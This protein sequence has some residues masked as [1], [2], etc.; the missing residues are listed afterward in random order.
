MTPTRLLVV[1]LGIS[2]AVAGGSIAAQQQRGAPAPPAAADRVLAQTVAAA[3]AFL[4]QLSP[5]QRAKAAYPFD[6]PQRKNWSN[7]P[8]GIFQRNSLRMGDMTGPQRDTA[9]ALM[10]TV[11]SRDGY[12]KITDIMNGDEV[13][14]NQ[15][16]GRT[17]GRPGAP[18]RGGQPGGGGRGGGVVF[19]KDEYYVAI[20][21][22]PSTST[23]W[24]IQFGGHHLGINL[25]MAGAH[26]VMTPSLP[27]A[28][29]AKYSLNGETIRPLGREN[30]KGFALINALDAAQRQQAILPYEVR[31]L[32]LG[33]LED[34]K[35][36]QPEGIL[37]SALSASQPAM[38]L[39][40]AHEWVGI[41]NDSAAA[42][43]M[44]EIR[45]NLPKTYFA[46]SGSTTNGQLAYYRIQG[47][48]VVIEYAPQQGDLDHIHTIYRDPTNDYGAK[49]VGK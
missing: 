11:L 48:T 15:G 41:L 49:L 13:L 45:A 21:G 29:P 16:G 35:V 32:V 3:N 31:D 20:L 4:G 9:L 22:T 14:K 25:T 42:E 43:R 30:D 24:M 23:P 19:G 2:L 46:W 44:A 39:E 36:I 33:P 26:S 40:L 28:Q 37:A 10:S 34:G 1:V 8:T 7:L 38:L 12:H 6:S 18:G 27:A 17:G 5:E 47:P